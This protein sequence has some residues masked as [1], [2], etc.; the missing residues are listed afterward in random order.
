MWFRG[1]PAAMLVSALL[2]LTG[3]AS[4]PA[5]S[6]PGDRSVDPAATSTRTN[7]GS[8]VTLPRA[9]TVTATVATVGA[10]TSIAPTGPPRTIDTD[11]QAG[12]TI[13][14]DQSF[15]GSV[16]AL[17]VGQHLMLTLAG[18]WTPPRTAGSP[19]QTDASRGYPDSPPATAMFSAVATGTAQITAGTEAACLHA[20]P[21][22]LIAQ[23]TF[24]LSVHVL[25]QRSQK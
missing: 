19:L 11:P 6:T 2:M 24:V 10:G 8:K 3:C 25:P 23:R 9:G 4:R 15:D 13:H 5:G 16:V 12:A 7:S 18:P 20:T 1:S 21:R 17:R 22:C 14:I